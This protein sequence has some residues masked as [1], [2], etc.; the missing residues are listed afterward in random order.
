MSTAAAPHGSSPAHPRAIWPAVFLASPLVLLF[1]LLRDPSVDPIVPA[2]E[3]HFAIVTFTAIAGEV[4]AAVLLVI[5]ERLREPRGFYIGLAFAAMA[6]F[7]FVHG[8]LTPGIIFERASTGIH[9]APLLGLSLAA[10]CLAL[11]TIRPGR[12]WILTR[13]RFVGVGLFVVWALFFGLSVWVPDF[14]SGHTAS[15]GT[16]VRARGPAQP[17]ASSDEYAVGV[18]AGWQDTRDNYSPTPAS[19]HAAS[20]YGRSDGKPWLG[21]A[22]CVAAGALISLTAVRYARQYRLSRLPSHATVVWGMLL[23]LESLLAFVFASVWRVSWWEYHVLAL[24]GIGVVVYGLSLDYQRGPGV[25]QAF[26]SLLAGTSVDTLQ[27]SYTEALT[28]LTAAV[29]ARDPYTRGHSEKVARLALAIGERLRLP[30]ESLRTLYYGGLLHDIGKIAISDSI[31]HKQGPLDAE[32]FAVIKE[33]PGRAEDIVTRIPSLR[34]L[35]GA[36]RWHHERLDGSG[37][38]DGLRGNAIPLDA[39]IL[40]VADVYDAMSSGRVYRSAFPLPEVIAWLREHAGTQLDV[41]CVDALLQV[42]VNDREST[43][44]STV[45]APSTEEP[46]RT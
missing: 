23:L 35:R 6:S 33:H 29:E 26:A 16:L 7:Y 13:R 1:L 4:L 39:R 43:G 24:L 37:Y 27:T 21:V 12:H 10:G 42:V 46:V 17:V 5:A 2:P 41:R 34:P 36:I 45:R 20:A 28:A 9:W 40:A 18:V 22:F 32:E 11:S 3:A 25:T 38:P 44:P 30:P 14:L 19:H 31:L 8:L 15:V